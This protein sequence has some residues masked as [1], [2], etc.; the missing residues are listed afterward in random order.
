MD[1]SIKVYLRQAES[2]VLSLGPEVDKS[3][4]RALQQAGVAAN[5]LATMSNAGTRS[6]NTSVKQSFQSVNGFATEQQRDL[7]R[8]LL[9][10]VQA[11]M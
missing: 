6:C 4:V 3:I 11:R 2:Q 1:A 9:P 8:S 10:L 5:R 7:N